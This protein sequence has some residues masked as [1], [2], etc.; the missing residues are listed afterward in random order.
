MPGEHGDLDDRRVGESAR[1]RYGA[2][3]VTASIDNGNHP[4]PL[5][6]GYLRSIRAVGPWSGERL[7]C[8]QVNRQVWP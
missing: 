3:C 4:Q 5:P 6:K 7:P 1:L 2:E 8:G